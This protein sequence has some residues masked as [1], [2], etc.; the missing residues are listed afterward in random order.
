MYQMLGFL[1]VNSFID[2]T[3]DKVSKLGELSPISRTFSSEVGIYSEEEFPDLRLNTFFAQ[4]GSDRVP[5]TRELAKEVLKIGNWLVTESQ[6]NHFD[7][8]ETAFEQKFRAEYKEKLTIEGIGKMVSNGR[9]WLPEYITFKL[10][11][12]KRENR[13][14][15]W[16]CDEAFQAQYD[17]F[18][19]RILPALRP[20]DDFFKTPEKVKEM[21]TKNTSAEGIAKLHEE[22]NSIADNHPYTL[23]LSHYYDWIN[24]DDKN[25]KIATV[26]TVLL[27]GK[28]ANNADLIKEQLADYVL[29]LS[30]YNRSDW[31]KIIPDLFIPTEFYLCPLWTKFS[32]PNL[33]L[34]GGLHSPIV[35]F[36]DVLPWAARTMYGY[37]LRHIAKYSVVFDTIFKSSAMIAC[38]HAQNRLAPIEFEKLWKDYA[39]IYTTSRDFNRISPETQDFIIKL[40]TMLVHAEV[41]TPESDIPTGFTRVKR[42]EMYYLTTT[43]NRVQYVMPLR[44]NFL[45]EIALDQTSAVTN[46]TV[47]P[48]GKDDGSFD[49]LINDII[50]ALPPG[51]ANGT[52]IVKPEPPKKPGTTVVLPGGQEGTIVVPKDQN[53]A[54]GIHPGSGDN[55]PS[56][57]AANESGNNENS[58]DVVPVD[59]EDVT[60]VNTMTSSRSP[61]I[62]MFAE[63]LMKITL[64]NIPKSL[65]ETLR[66]KLTLTH[67]RPNNQTH[68]E[69]FKDGSLADW[70]VENVSGDPDKVSISASIRASS[71][72][73]TG[74]PL[75]YVENFK[76]PYTDKRNTPRYLE[77]DLTLTLYDSLGKVQTK[78]IAVSRYEV[79]TSAT[80]NS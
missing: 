16:F 63:R 32:T 13:Y 77:G 26:W 40:N 29:S 64:T 12:D 73:A 50:N 33:Q 47:N 37:E 22:T 58:L 17:K 43:H 11:A 69:T 71:N 56:T 35:P 7:N 80:G 68:V 60:F 59:E 27:Y 46:P 79:T 10:A 19:L 21:L 34:Q 61:S 6:L 78:N 36:R 48:T 70:N 72:A 1:V 49:S 15:I 54:N 65:K 74:Y 44:Y 20:V 30:D 23:L 66:A 75:P 42:G 67:Y 38:G 5:L 28:A 55:Q 14:K 52:T 57:P 45:G 3:I 51:T 31:E 24:P 9:Y 62:D 2:N 76:G 53:N 18:E 8:D 4:E 25:D 39:N 41:M